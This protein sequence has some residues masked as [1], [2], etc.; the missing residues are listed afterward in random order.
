MKCIRCGET[1]LTLFYAS[2]L[3]HSDYRC[4]RCVNLYQKEYRRNNRD[5]VNANQK[6]FY[7]WYAPKLKSSI[8]SHYSNGKMCCA[9]CNSMTNLSIDHINGGGSKHLLSL[10]FNSSYQFYLWLKKNN[11]P[12]G[13]RVLCISCNSH[14]KSPKG[15]KCQP[16]SRLVKRALRL[17]LH[18]SKDIVNSLQS[19]NLTRRAILE[20]IRRL[21]QKG[22]VCR[23]SRGEYE[24]HFQ[25]HLF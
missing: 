22:E 18:R 21:T 7:S 25:T 13:Y 12:E 16:T 11:Y 20:A 4:K 3:K 8:L 1:D 17:G 14:I 23:I 2:I 10:G 19:P 24:L 5:K 6:R 15:R 9:V